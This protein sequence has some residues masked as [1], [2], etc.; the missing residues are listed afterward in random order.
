MQIMLEEEL[1]MKRKQANE[2]D[3]ERSDKG[4]DRESDNGDDNGMIKRI[5]KG[6]D[7]GKDKGM[8][9]TV[10][11]NLNHHNVQC[12][13][14]QMQPTNGDVSLTVNNTKINNCHHHSNKYNNATR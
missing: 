3:E 8:N 2:G 7:K 4:S 11:N 13:L 12:Y 1:R 6:N 5:D 10:S 9:M 14:F